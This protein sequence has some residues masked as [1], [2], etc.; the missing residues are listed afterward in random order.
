MEEIKKHFG[1]PVD[2]VGLCSSAELVRFK[3]TANTA[4]AG[5]DARH[6]SGLYKPPDKPMSLEEATSFVSR[7]LY[8][9]LRK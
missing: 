9:A 5:L 4:A 1:K 7:L 3:R 6:A 2:K 8:G